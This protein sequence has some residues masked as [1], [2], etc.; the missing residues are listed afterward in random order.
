M[1]RAAL[2]GVPAAVA[3]AIA[4]TALAGLHASGP[5]APD[6]KQLEDLSF[7]SVCTYSHRASDDPIVY[8]DQP[9]R[10]HDHSF[11][12]SVSTDAFSTPATLRAAPT[13]CDRAEDTAAY[14]APTLL[15]DDKPVLPVDATVYYRRRTLTRVRPFPPGLEIV[16]GDSH[17][18]APQ[19]TRIVWWDCG[20]HGQ[21][22]PS[23][24]VPTCPSGG[25]TTLRLNVR[26]PDCWDGT[27]LD[28]P[29]HQSH[30]A[31]SSRGVCPAARPVAMPSI[32]LVVQYPIAG[33]PGVT[34]AS[35]GAL[36]GHAD[37]VSAWQ[38]AGLERLVRYCLN[39]LRTCGHTPA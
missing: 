38:Q 19:S 8:P 33:G 17:A 28:S 18:N 32:T 35:G 9:D 25:S 34:L 26:F 31:Y 6:L 21:V 22:A 2:F 13:T 37:F 24:R 10:S 11:F 20:T 4:A 12:G 5:S 1:R 3:A 39:A 23:A 14:W 29:D 27:R 7:I 36:S 16:A 30:M 15:V